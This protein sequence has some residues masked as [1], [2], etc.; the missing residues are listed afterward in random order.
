MVRGQDG[1]TPQTPFANLPYSTTFTFIPN[2][3]IPFKLTSLNQIRFTDSKSPDLLH[4]CL[5]HD[6]HLDLHLSSIKHALPISD[7]RFS[8][9]TT[10]NIHFTIDFASLSSKV[11]HPVSPLISSFLS[12]PT[13]QSHSCCCCLP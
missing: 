3:T 5:H 11:L 9:K 6:H 4:I 1:P 12:F 2:F 8:S 13:S 7:T 10:F